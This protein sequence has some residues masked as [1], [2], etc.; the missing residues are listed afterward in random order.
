MAKERWPKSRIIP[1]ILISVTAGGFLAWHLVDP[2]AR[3]TGWTVALLVILF[4]PWLGAVFESL[5]FAGAS[6]KWRREVEEE[7]ERQADQIETMQFLL[8]RFLSEPERQLLLRLASG[9][10]V[11][12]E[13]GIGG[14]TIQHVDKL[15]RMGLIAVK[16][17]L[18]ES[19]R[20]L[21]AKGHTSMDVSVVNEIFVLT[22]RGRQY[23]SLIAKLP[24]ENGQIYPDGSRLR[25]G[26]STPPL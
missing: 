9:D 22:D 6:V 13:D 26:A 7:Q 4:L 2:T 21:E 25:T 15:R 17:E 19:F 20:Q 24:A 16:A 5:G 1:S 12:I 8:A 11:K 23:L 3:V 14:S 18:L 10:S